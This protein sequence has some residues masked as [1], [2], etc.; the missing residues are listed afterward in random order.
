MNI[1]L[2]AH[3]SRGD[4]Y[5][6]IALASEFIRH[7]HEA[8]MLTQGH[9]SDRLEDAGICR[10]PEIAGIHSDQEV[11]RRPRPLCKYA[12]HQSRFLAGHKIDLFACLGGI[13]LENGC[14][15]VFVAG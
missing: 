14:D 4:V 11:R 12:L 1:L 5:P 9:Y 3:G 6:M 13:G 7:G 8:V 10:V 2:T 15:Q